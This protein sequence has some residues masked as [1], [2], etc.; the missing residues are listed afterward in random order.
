MSEPTIRTSEGT[1]RATA[2]ISPLPWRYEQEDH[3][4]SPRAYSI[5]DGNG[6]RLA[7]GFLFR[8]V[9]SLCATMNGV[10]E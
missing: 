5:F 1:R 2:P 10:W 7:V 8:D 4:G 3:L 6:E 9:E